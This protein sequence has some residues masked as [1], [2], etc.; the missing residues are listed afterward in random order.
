VRE[1]I[2]KSRKAAS[3]V[4]GVPSW[5][6]RTMLRRSVVTALLLLG[7]VAATT[8]T[9]VLLPT[10]WRI[11]PPSGPA[12]SLGLFPQGVALSPHGTRIAVVEAGDGPPALRIL[13]AASLRLIRAVAL[14]SA[15]GKPAWLDA[16]HVLVAGAG[17]D[18]LD[19]VDV[20]DGSYR[21][22]PIGPRTWPANVAIDRTTA[23]VATVD[24][25]NGS[26]TLVDLATR[27]VTTIA[28]GP[29]PSDAAFTAGGERL[30][31]ALRG[32]SAL[33]RIDVASR[34]V[35]ILPV[36][37]HPSALA[38]GGGTLYVAQSDDDSVRAI[39]L[40]D[41][42]TI[43]VTP[44]GL[45]GERV[46]GFGASP[47]A[48]AIA[49]GRLYISL[50]AENAVAT[51]A[52]AAPQRIDDIPTGWYPS[53]VAALGTHLYVVDAKGESSPANPRF[54]PFSPN[55][56]GYVGSSLDGSLRSIDVTA[57]VLAQSATVLADAQPQ[58]L[59]PQHTIIRPDGPIRH[60]IYIIKENR[61]Y[62]EVLGDIARADGDPSLVWFGKTNT[63]NQHALAERFGI[64]DR[65]FADA[66]VS[67]DGHNW[68]TAAFANDYLER[69]WPSVYA[70]R[71]SL[72]DFE[73]GATASVPHNGYLWDDAQR[74]HVSFRDYGEFVTNPTSASAV[75][76]THMPGLLGHIDP[77]YPGFDLQISD[78]TR[79]AL[80]KREFDA[81]VARGD[82]PQLEIVRLPND[83]TEGTR[84]GA[85]TP[86]AY[87]AQNDYA[88]GEIVA[89]VSHSPYWATTAVFAIEDDAQNGADHV[90]DQRT[91]LYVASPYAAPG[92]HHTGY[93]T[94]SVLRTIEI[95]L[96]MAP[97]SV[98]DTVAEPLYTAFAARPDL[99]AFDAIAPEIDVRATNARTAYG[100]SESERLDFAHADDVDP[101]LF[102]DILAHAV[103]GRL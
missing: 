3:K 43:A 90:D 80:W 37:M 21:A 92:V 34:R 30:Y 85:L 19:D 20:T 49:D 73:D 79:Y 33:A 23:S 14:K 4:A 77:E 44:V 39:E 58:W 13:D 68:S 52:L 26:V 38:I 91:T 83:H 78:Q 50:G 65:T 9:A 5:H 96:G 46:R 45:R 51:F 60:V 95:V 62:D 89:A 40:A 15:F 81:Y 86:Q 55:A 93:S 2:L 70:G 98:Y 29:H 28:V 103:G 7:V 42:R 94:A 71:R 56:D 61:T 32:S 1:A 11:T 64:F 22:I 87:V 76:T 8:V 16:T 100:A 88:L 57:R 18:A 10:G 97:M 54:D 102:N 74:A 84:P 69:M 75:V 82:L 27:H 59:P 53:G 17:T 48:L 41:D 66:Q 101:A 31:V 25:G 36:G 24:D 47:N 12:V 99:R 6:L 67:A 72:Y 35:R 63:P